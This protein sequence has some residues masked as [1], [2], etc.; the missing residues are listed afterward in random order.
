MKINN[1]S[2]KTFLKTGFLVLAVFISLF[3]LTSTVSADTTIGGG[4]PFAVRGFVNTHYG[5]VIPND[6]ALHYDSTTALKICQIAGFNKVVSV[7]SYSSQY[8]RSGFQSC[9]DNKL[10]TWNGSTFAL[11]DACSVGNTWISNV[12]CGNSCTANVSKKCVGNAVY[13]YDSCGIQ[14]GLAQACTT[15]QTCQNDQ[16]VNIACNSDSAC[17]TNGF[18][19]GPYCQGNNIYQNYKT[20]TCNNPGTAN[21][22]CSNSIVP[23]LKATCAGNQTCSN[24]ACVN[25]NI[26]CSTNSQCGTNGFTGGLFC[27]ANNVYQSYK[28]YTCNNPGAANSYCSNLTTPQLKTVCSGNQTCSNGSC[29]NVNIA[30]FANTDCGNSGY[31]GGSFCQNNSVYKNYKT[32]TCNNPGTANSSCSDSVA[33][34]LKSMC[35]GNQT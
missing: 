27:M 25:V 19:D 24:G 17:G 35:T 33:P 14:G 18:T 7:D 22:S 13:W 30:C 29:A 15:N 11:A 23:Q 8:G 32:Y 5:N 1:I 12:V 9:A 4:D 28:T 20:Y 10:A 31:T 2:N 3:Y 34:Q 16:C 6:S 26:A 21:S